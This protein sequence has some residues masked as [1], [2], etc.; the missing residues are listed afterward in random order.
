MIERDIRQT[1]LEMNGPLT[2]D[3]AP[4][5]PRAF[6]YDALMGDLL[7]LAASA[8]TTNLRGLKQFVK[9][10]NLQ[11]QELMCNLRLVCAATERDWLAAAEHPFLPTVNEG[12]QQMAATA[13]NCS[14]AVQLEI[15]ARKSQKSTASE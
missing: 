10:T 12:V 6:T 8:L 2:E 3:G 4:Y 14:K 13:R 7:S 5:F 11:A 9:P 15:A 1:Q